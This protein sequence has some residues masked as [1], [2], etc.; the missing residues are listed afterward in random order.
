MGNLADGFLFFSFLFFRLNPTSSLTTSR[1]I[2]AFLLAL[3]SQ[4]IW[5]VK[6]AFVQKTERALLRRAV[7][8]ERS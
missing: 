5:R 7:S 1:E 8:L 4:I 3:R 2:T 6:T